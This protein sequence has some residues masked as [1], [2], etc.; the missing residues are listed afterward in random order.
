MDA[1]AYQLVQVNNDLL[2]ELVRGERK[3]FRQNILRNTLAKIDDAAV[4]RRTETVLTER[5]IV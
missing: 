1:V 3:K 2:R 4:L 5:N